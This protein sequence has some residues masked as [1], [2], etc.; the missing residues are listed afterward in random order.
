MGKR[1]GADM[2]TDKQPFIGSEALESGLLKRHE[3]RRDFRAVLPNVYVNKRIRLTLKQRAMAAWLWSRRE[4]VVAGLTASAL[5]GA[6]WIPEDSPIELIWSNARR[7]RG[8]IT[9]DDVIFDC[10]IQLIDGVPVTTP[11]RTAFDMARRGILGDA[12]ARV[13]ALGAAT[14]LKPDAMLALADLHRRAR[15]L[16]QLEQVIDLYDPGAQSPK[17][18]WLRKL[19]IDEGFPRPQTQIPILS[20][21]GMPKYYLDMGW[22]DQMVAVEY[23]GEQHAAQLGYDIVRNEYIAGL[24]WSVVRVAAGHRRP[25]IIARVDREWERAQCRLNSTALILR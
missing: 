1:H 10:E 18:T 23:D 12:L 2:D 7:P 4:A 22:E 8:V 5:H 20:P 16:R 14:R 13:D 21:D 3:L 17:E 24:D 19:L 25:S 6:K 9:R 15:G 11:E